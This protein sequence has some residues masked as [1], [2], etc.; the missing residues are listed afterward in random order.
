MGKGFLPIAASVLFLLSYS[1]VE[2]EGV[3]TLEIIPG[4]SIQVPEMAPDFRRFKG[5]VIGAK[6]YSNGNMLAVIETYTDD[7]DIFV[8]LLFVKIKEKLH[9]V[10]MQA[11]Y[12]K[13]G[14]TD[15][16]EDTAFTKTGKPSGKL[17]RVKKGA[18]LEQI[19]PF[20][21]RSVI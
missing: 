10:G 17:A 21:D 19:E 8:L 12:L 2:A 16:Y 4:H 18:P 5:S 3:K 15:L 20:L 14:I 13:T 11:A 9:L 1:L 7:G 6:T